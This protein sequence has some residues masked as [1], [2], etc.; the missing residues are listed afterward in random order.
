LGW[1]N[2]TYSCALPLSPRVFYPEYPENPSNL[3]E[4]IRKA[5]ID[6][7]LMIK[8]LAKLIGTSEGSVVNWEQRNRVP[9]KK[10][11]ESPA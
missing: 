10:F 7:G 11:H 2:G 4:T 5:R 1:E 3:G 9:R 6:R 8:E